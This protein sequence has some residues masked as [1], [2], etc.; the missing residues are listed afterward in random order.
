MEEEVDLRDYINVLVKW[1]WLIIWITVISM[2]V[3]GVYSY[4]IAKP[5]YESSGML[6]VNPKN[7]KVNIT[8]PGELLNPLT[9][10][11]EISVATYTSIVKSTNVEEKVLDDLKLDLPPYNFTVD[12]FDKIIQVGNPKNTTLIKVSVQLGDP[13]IAKDVVNDILQETVKYVNYLNTYQLKVNSSSLEKQ[14]LAA[15]DELEQVQKSI[16]EFNSQRDNLSNLS[17]ERDTYKTALNSYLSQLLSLDAQINQYKQQITEA[18]NKLKNEREYLTTEKSILD[19]PLISQLAQDL[20]N[21]NIIYLS[22]LKVNSQE[23]N[24]VYLNL[25]AKLANYAIT[26]SGLNARKDTLNAL[27][28]QAQDKIHQLDEEIN[29]KQLQLDQLNRRLAIAK[30]NYSQIANNYEQSKLAQDNILASLTIATEP[31]VPT[32]PVKPKKLFNIAVAGTAGFFF[33][34]LLAFF[35]EY[36]QGSGDNKEKDRENT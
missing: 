2:L 36:M 29:A 25:K 10:L 27:I 16:A 3:A 31:V 12:S 30:N 15:K 19:D 35:L 33:A 26:L 21:E 23:I 22:K 20:S 5:I 24:P 4:V 6:L 9:Y 1:K 34:I 11:P 17:Q 18:E 14:Y 8:S 28:T 7:A 32:H 13:N